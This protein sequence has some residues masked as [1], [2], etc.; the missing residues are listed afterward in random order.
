MHLIYF[1]SGNINITLQK[2]NFETINLRQFCYYNID[3]CYNAALVSEQN[4]TYLKKSKIM[5]IP[6]DASK[7]F[8]RF[9]HIDDCALEP[10]KCSQ[11]IFDIN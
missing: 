6:E 5:V 9:P 2:K 1:V 11:G 7:H 10:C 3:M 4:T 8:I